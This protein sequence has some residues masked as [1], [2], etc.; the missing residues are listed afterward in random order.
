MTFLW[1]S[2]L[3]VVLALSGNACEVQRR[4]VAADSTVA[5]DSASVPEPTPVRRVAFRVPQLAEIAD[6]TVRASILRG[7]ALLNAPRDSMPR[8]AGNKLACTSCHQNNGTQKHGMPWIGVY[9][10]FPQYRSRFGGTQIIEDRINDC[11][12]RSLNGT[13]LAPE[14]RDMRDIVAYM[15]FLS[16][17]VPVGAEVDGQGIPPLTPLKADSARGL[18]VY[19]ARCARCH[20]GDGQGNAAYP[21]V[22]GAQSYNIGAGMARLRTA[23]GFI[24]ARMPQDS[25][26]VLSDQEAFDVARFINSHARPDFK[27]KERDW[28]RGDPPP[29]VAYPT[30]ASRRTAA[31][32]TTP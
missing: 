20:G 12:K 32:A 3:L 7:Q 5:A 29:D 26:G 25:A 10:R 6:S 2:A 23:A 8:H 18:A 16:H 11:I 28:P 30:D 21:P 24:R 22:W 31:R 27:G 15:A 14:S 4:S 9:A 1:R 17:G 13:P 19:R